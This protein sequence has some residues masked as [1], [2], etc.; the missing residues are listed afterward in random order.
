MHLL[1]LPDGK[2]ISWYL[3]K[4]QEVAEVIDEFGGESVLFTWRVSPTV[5]Y[6]R[7]QVVEN[8]VDL[9]YCREHGIEV[10]Q[11]KSGGGAVYADR[12]NRM[13]SYIS[14]S[15]HSEQVFQEFLQL[16]V[17][18]LRK[19]GFEAVT[20]A[21]NDVLVDGYKVSGTACYALPNATI[22]HGTLLENVDL[23]QMT[24]ALTPS[25]EKLQKHGVESV[26]QRVKNLNI[27]LIIP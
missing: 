21:H 14:P 2:H 13:I 6:G 20:T 4:E 7:H 8:E 9:N 19:N 18:W 5:I 16:V 27:K 23:E 15:T 26:R 11:R 17:G 10:Y 12:G 24:R 3:D 22:V 1:N 25:Q